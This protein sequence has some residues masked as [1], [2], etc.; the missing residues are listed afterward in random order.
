MFCF[1]DQEQLHIDGALFSDILTF[2]IVSCSSFAAL[3]VLLSSLPMSR[4]LPMDPVLVP[5]QTAGQGVLH[6]NCLVSEELMNSQTFGLHMRIDGNILE[7]GIPFDLSSG[8]TN[9]L[10]SKQLKQS[11]SEY[12]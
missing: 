2:Y 5:A 8:F 1:T 12:S 4:H 7:P 6:T 11:C 10:I 9:F 3:L